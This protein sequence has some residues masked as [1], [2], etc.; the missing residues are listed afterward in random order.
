MKSVG[1]GGM[2]WVH[3]LGAFLQFATCSTSFWTSPSEILLRAKK[4]RAEENQS[5]ATLASIWP[6]EAKT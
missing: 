2:F 1:L 5:G 6:Y 4:Y 3:V